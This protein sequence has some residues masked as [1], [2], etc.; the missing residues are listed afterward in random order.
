MTKKLLIFIFLFILAHAA[1]SAGKPQEKL[2]LTGTVVDAKTA[3]IPG[4]KVKLIQQSGGRETEVATDETGAFSFDNPPPGDY[5]L[6]IIASGFKPTERKLAVGTSAVPPMMIRLEVLQATEKVTV[7]ANAI[8][9]SPEQNA[10]RFHV[11]D[12]FLSGLPMLNGDP[13]AVVSMFTDPGVSGARGP[14]LIVDG[15][16]TDTLDLPL[17]SIKNI[18]VNQNPYSAEFGRPGKGRIEVKTKHRIHQF[19]GT[20]FTDF[21]NSAFDARNTFASSVPFHQRA[22]S[23]AELEG[24]V[25]KNVSLLVSARYD[26]NNET[27]IVHAQTLSGPLVQN[28]GAPAR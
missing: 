26:L 22:I 8:P 1:E 2:A 5:T 21:L 4:A 20:V 9:I 27:A 12:S 19:H 7:S 14:Q 23:E 6:S 16:P 10:D 15:V 18:T 3:P 11:D 25:T 17:S 24:P 28:F 13:L